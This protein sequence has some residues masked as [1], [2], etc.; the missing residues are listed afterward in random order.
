MSNTKNT[1]ACGR[2]RPV[3]D[4]DAYEGVPEFA[5]P[6][7]IAGYECSVCGW[8]AAYM[9]C[10]GEYILPDVCPGCGADMENDEDGGDWDD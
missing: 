2:W 5:G 1:P 6:E 3:Y 7:Q 8:V 10:N 4:A 9:D